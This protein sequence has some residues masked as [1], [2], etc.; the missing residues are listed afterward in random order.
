M[1][2]ARKI[3]GAIVNSSRIWGTLV[4]TYI[5][6]KHT[7]QSLSESDLKSVRHR[8]IYR[9]I[10][11]LSALRHQLRQP[12]E[13]ETMNKQFNIEHKKF[14]N[15]LEHQ[16]KLEDDLTTY[17]SEADKKYVL[18]KKNPAMHLIDVQSEDLKELFNRGLI[19]NFQHIELQRVLSNL[20]EHQGKCERIK[21]FPYPRQF[22]TLNLYFIWLFILLLPFGMLPEFEKL[23][24]S[25]TW[26]VIPFCVMVSWIFHTMDKIGESTENPFQGGA[27]DVPITALSRG[28]EI[29]LREMLGDV[30]LPELIKPQNS[31]L[32]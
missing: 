26:L 5:A 22:S 11:W 7:F 4:K 27:N 28:I 30:D 19:E 3:Y 24:H 16:T 25:L 32:M 14:F 15:V 17:L 6:N 29:D 9:H 2:E 21:N 31:I 20:H 10:A 1:W 18:S 12:R 13:W 8:L 23:G